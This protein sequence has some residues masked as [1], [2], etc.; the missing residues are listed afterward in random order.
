MN[1]PA[2]TLT[3]YAL[4][5]LCV[6]FALR[7]ALSSPI[8][9]SLRMWMIV[10]FASIAGASMVGGTM[11]GFVDSGAVTRTLWWKASLLS[12]GV[13]G[14][15]IWGIMGSVAFP[16]R[17]RRGIVS[18]AAL[19][20]FASYSIVVVTV[21]DSFWVAVA[22]YVLPTVTLLVVLLAQYLKRRCPD[23]LL[24]LSGIGLTLAA[25]GV[26]HAKISLH[27][28]HFDFN[29]TYHLVQVLALW[30]IHWWA[31]RRMRLAP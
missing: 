3:D 7:S 5:A 14:W 17:V 8:D 31:A 6:F 10:F 15:S 1:E 2:V 9:R 26:Q 24:G 13:T 19:V 28:V 12:L 11:H 22:Q 23:D 27:P 18:A 21:S 4:A 30:L 16:D 25:A 29:A 20:L